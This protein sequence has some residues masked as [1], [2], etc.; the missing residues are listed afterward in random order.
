MVYTA[1]RILHAGPITFGRD[2]ANVFGL[3]KLPDRRTRTP[4]PCEQC[5]QVT[6]GTD[7]L[8]DYKSPH[9]HSKAPHHQHDGCLAHLSGCK[10]E[11]V[12]L[13]TMEA[14]EAWYVM[15]QRFKAVH[16]HT[17]WHQ[18]HALPPPIYIGAKASLERQ[19]S[20]P[21]PHRV[22]YATLRTPI[23]TDANA[24]PKYHRAR[25]KPV[26]NDR[27]TRDVTPLY[28]IC[29]SIPSKSKGRARTSSLY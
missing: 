22:N 23:H 15:S 4:I 16:E 12:K 2:F 5:T 28:Q 6:G 9:H 13:P 26:G 1:R 20:N 19:N 29:L 25:L 7:K 21:I 18:P 8:H 24:S 17:T 14:N 27:V 10:C 3:K 11:R